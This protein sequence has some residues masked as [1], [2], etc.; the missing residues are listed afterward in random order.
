MPEPPEPAE[1]R[2]P[3]LWLRRTDQAVA[4]TVIALALMAMAGH[5]LYC[6]G[7]RGRVIEVDDVR[8]GTIEFTVDINEADWPEL[9][10]LPGIGETL[11]KRIV[12]TR[13]EQGGFREVED[14]RN[15]RGIGPLTL[16]RIRPYLRPLPDIEATADHADRNY[17]IP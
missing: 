8:P 12:A 7:H 16:E 1:S 11:A 6:G 10:V 15:V 9:T 13:E 4:G 14:L 5:W 3:R 17:A 2:W